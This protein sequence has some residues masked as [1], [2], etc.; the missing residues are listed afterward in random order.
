MGAFKLRESVD[1]DAAAIAGIYAHWVRY[2]L[3]SFELEP[4]DVEEISRRRAG[5]VGENYP[6]LI[7]E[8]DHDKKVIG[9]AY[10][11]PYRSRPAYRF[12]CEDSVYIAPYACGRGVG[13]ELLKAL[14]SRCETMDLRAMVA[15]IGDSSNAPSIGLHKALG[16]SHVGTLPAI[17]WK[18]ERWVDSVLMVRPLGEGDTSAPSSGSI[19]PHS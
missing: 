7:A 3:A 2:G 10:V 17:G 5:I 8:D 19:T 9:Y 18:Q 16:F 12:A 14:I 11:G 1:D 13:K 6:Y 15:V 4:P